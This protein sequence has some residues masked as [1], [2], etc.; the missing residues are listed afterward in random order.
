MDRALTILG[1]ALPER[2]WDDL[3]AL[4]IGR[5]DA[6]LLEL[7][8]RTFGDTL[9]GTA[10][11]A[12]CGEKLEFPLSIGELMQ[13][14]YESTEPGPTVDGFRPLPTPTGDLTFRFLDS[15]DLAAAAGS[16]DPVAARYT[17]AR[18]ALANADGTPLEREPDAE[19]TALLAEEISKHDRFADITLSLVCPACGRGWDTTLDIL[20]Y[21]WEEISAA[22]LGLLHDVHLIASAYGWREEEIL[23]IPAARRRAYIDMIL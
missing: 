13:A 8:A 10:S 1:R 17:L 14:T 15:R 3:A 18:R 20:S 5:R 12:E 22:A 21:F 2:S 19:T 16:P 11:C 23:A 7:R 4:S 6:L 9:E